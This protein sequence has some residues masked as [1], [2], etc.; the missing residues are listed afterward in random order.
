MMRSMQF[1]ASKVALNRYLIHQ[2]QLEFKL[3]AILSA[4]A[5]DKQ[6]PVYHMGVGNRASLD[7]TDIPKKVKDFYDAYYEKSKVSMIT[8]G[9]KYT[10]DIKTLK[11]ELEN[12]LAS[13]SM[14]SKPAKDE[15]LLKQRAPEAPKDTYI[16]IDH[17][18]SNLIQ[19]MYA[20]NLDPDELTH[21]TFVK[22]V[23][24]RVLDDVLIEKNKLALGV[25]IS[26]DFNENF[27]WLA[28]EVTTT[29][30]GRKNPSQIHGAITDLVQNLYK[31]L[32]SYDKMAIFIWKEYMLSSKASDPMK[33]LSP[34]LSNLK[35]FGVGRLFAGSIL[36][37]TYS[38]PI[39]ARILTQLREKGRFVT[40][41]GNFDTDKEFKN[42]YNMIFKDEIVK[43]D[44]FGADVNVKS[45]LRLNKR[46]DLYE[47]NYASTTLSRSES[48]AAIRDA[49]KNKRLELPKE[50]IEKK[51]I[52]TV[53]QINDLKNF[54]PSKKYEKLET[55]IQN[56]TD[57]LND[58]YNIPMASFYMLM[59]FD[60]T[61]DKKAY[62]DVSYWIS[63][64][65]YRLLPIVIE[66]TSFRNSISVEHDT[67]GMTV[68]IDSLPNASIGLLKDLVAALKKKEVTQD[69]HEYAV[70]VIYRAGLSRKQP[71]FDASSAI[72]RYVFEGSPNGADKIKYAKDN[73]L[74]VKDKTNLKDI[75]IGLIHYEHA[76]PSMSFKD[77][78]TEL[79]DFKYGVAGFAHVKLKLPEKDKT[80]LIRVEKSNPEDKSIGFTA[81]NFVG[82]NTPKNI[83]LSFTLSK[84]LF[85]LAFDYLRTQKKLGYTAYT[86]PLSIHSHI[87]FCL[88]I[89]GDKSLSLTQT[90]A[91][92]FWDVADKYLIASSEK[93]VEQIVNILHQLNKVPFHSLK[94][95][96]K[97]IFERLKDGNSLDYKIQILEELLKVKKADLVAFFD[98]SFKKETR[99]IIAESLTKE[100]L[101]QPSIEEQ[102]T[103]NLLN[104]AAT[105][106]T[107][108]NI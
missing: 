46:V 7:K 6:S 20:I 107:V 98:A 50:I 39:M 66:S 101:V 86:S 31:Y 29:I 16:M 78:Q 63:I 3:K 41:V 105:V 84:L 72:S 12:S 32:N 76:G 33:R 30:S 5:Y 99:R 94:E 19:Y 15:H 49:L 48:D 45:K 14:K 67:S 104:S 87:A 90:E 68:S 65:K 52:P 59:N 37:D 96:S 79:S 25:S 10:F 28:I 26:T 11:A 9:N 38:E 51:F 35:L 47:V 70:D 58:G 64:I 73:A 2:Q 23:L 18:S 100:Q 54:S 27:V 13:S 88:I 55:G 53:Q 43:N 93:Q 57:I 106:E 85:T 40:V 8:I 42:D 21:L 102:K 62:L 61:V 95:E 24:K 1:K 36:L 77:A 81:C 91:E 83:A 92:K 60:L 34:I 4:E 22:I 75:K 108:L 97:F 56:Y 89:Q 44:N 71:T 82:D 17:K 74:F 69:E 80:V 103:F